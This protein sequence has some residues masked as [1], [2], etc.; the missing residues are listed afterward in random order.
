MRFQIGAMSVGD[1]L[2]RGVRLLLARLGT[3]YALQFIVLAPVFVMQLA[4]P[5][6][7]TGVPTGGEASPF[8]LVGGLLGIL[9]LTIILAPIGSAATLHVIAQ[10]FI[11][12]R[13]TLAQALRFALGRFG[14]LL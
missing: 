13:V 1:I 2:D 11:D 7:V 10:E 12:Q 3:F 6:M 8:A 9:V 14:K 5:E 4:F